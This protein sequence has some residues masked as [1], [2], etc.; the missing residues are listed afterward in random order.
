[1]RAT[2]RR[3][4][5]G[6]PASVDGR[7]DQPAERCRHLPQRCGVAANTSQLRVMTLLDHIPV[8]LLGRRGDVLARNAMVP[9]VL[10]TA[11]PPGSSF[12][13]YMFLDPLTRERIMNR[14]DF[15]RATVGALRRETGRRPHDRRLAAFVHELCATDE[16]VSPE[17]L[18]DRP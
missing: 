1:M 14:T 11:M 16:Q 12:P 4:G 9:A 15:A 2:E 6:P 18:G 7:R 17:R 8:L 3:D 10:G 13:R 5:L